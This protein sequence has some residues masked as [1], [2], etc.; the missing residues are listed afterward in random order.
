V[1]ASAAPADRHLV[2]TWAMRDSPAMKWKWMG[3]AMWTAALQLMPEVA[4][5]DLILPEL[6]DEPG[7][8]V[9]P[10]PPEPESARTGCARR[11][12]LSAAGFD[13]AALALS[14]GALALWSRRS[15][16]RRLACRDLSW[17][18]SRCT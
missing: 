4:S 11:E 9:T 15:A 10:P 1:L 18:R 5:A 8:P 16:R 17:S 13:A 12:A 6:P 3:V 2:A 7:A 14:C